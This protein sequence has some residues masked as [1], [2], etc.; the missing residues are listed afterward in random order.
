MIKRTIEISTQPMHLTTR[1]GQLLLLRKDGPPKRLP[2]KPLNL[3]A[4]IP[5]EDL[6]VVL[7]EH[8]G[9][10]Y[11]H[12]ALSTLLSHDAAVVICGPDHL[13]AGML[14]PMTDHSEVVHRLHEQIAIKKPLR[15]RLWQQIV[16]AKIRAQA[17]NLPAGSSVR[18]R[19]LRLIRNVRS[20]DPTNVEA[21][22]ARAYWQVWLERDSGDA[23]TIPFRRDPAGPPPNS[24]LNYGYSVL[25]AAVARAIVSAGLTPALGIH[26]R[27]RAN[28]F[29]LADD[30]VEPLRPLVDEQ[31]RELHHDGQTG[32][33]PATKAALLELLTAR[34]RTGDGTGPLMVSLH[35]Y[36]A[37]FVRCLQ[38]EA[39]RLTIPV[40]DP[41]EREDSQGD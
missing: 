19:L 21:Q 1:A 4:S 28:T 3:A 14:L 5:C 9:T 24:F 11:S 29:C 27:N 7:V 18:T 8:G 32:L 22:A 10:T 36:V 38:G 6:G 25:R 40:A 13:P 30:L 37:S 33:L 23:G 12:A 17:E 34:V 35:K 26:H 31:V 39:D 20:G 15:K 2:G 41:S 16:R